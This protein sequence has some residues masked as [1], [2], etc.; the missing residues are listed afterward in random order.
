MSI[1][2][3]SYANGIIFK[4]LFATNCIIVR[5]RPLFSHFFTIIFV[6]IW[7]L[8]A[9]NMKD[10]L[11]VS[12]TKN[13]IEM[14]KFKLISKWHSSQ[15]YQYF[16]ILFCCQPN[17]A[18]KIISLFEFTKILF[19]LWKWFNSIHVLRIVERKIFAL[20]YNHINFIIQICYSPTVKFTLSGKQQF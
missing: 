5:G 20:V 16:L 19:V 2:F 18:S 13:L 11:N 9:R 15:G 10:F 1:A 7:D 12:L 3:H 6:T 14:V 17:S 8:K 4:L